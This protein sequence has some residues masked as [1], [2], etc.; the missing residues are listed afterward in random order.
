[1]TISGKIQTGLTRAMDD[2]SL[3]GEGPIALCANY[4]SVTSNLGRGL[5]ALVAAGAPVTTLLTPEH[6]YWGAVQAGSSAGDGADARTG[7]PILDTYLVE[8]AQ[9]DSLL[10]KSGAQ[11]I[12]IDLQDIGARFYTYMWTMFD[13][14]CSAARTG[15]SLVVLDRPNPLGR[16]QAG[17]GLDPACASFV[18]RVS[19]PMQH[20]LTLGE[21]AR[22]FNESHVPQASG[23]MADLTVIEVQGWDG[24]VQAGGAWVMP[25]PNMPTLNSAILY[26]ATG[27]LEGTTLSEGRGTTK[28][29]E[30]FG[31]EWTDGRLAAALR[32][33]NLP[34]I[35]VREAMFRPTFSKWAETSVHGA[36]FHLVDPA[37]FDAIT[38]AHTLLRTVADLYPEQQLWREPEAGRPPFLDLLWG[39]SSLRE[40]IDAGASL[41][42]ILQSA[43]QAPDAPEGTTLYP[44]NTPEVTS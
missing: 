2:P 10:E 29:F 8:D 11:Q 20:G 12:V 23:C 9:L 41:A 26:P 5:D 38:T 33:Q 36:Q 44:T 31:A 28:P 3:L 32:E 22:W 30:L 14:L 4:T 19:I 6:G 27:L 1:M 21:L 24:G 15:R 40:G 35:I 39:S 16:S 18:G 7:L 43:P 42:E 37:A 25:S 13:L 34:G 17:P